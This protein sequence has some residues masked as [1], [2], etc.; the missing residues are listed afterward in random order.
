[1]GAGPEPAWAVAVPILLEAAHA[2]LPASVSEH[3]V[4]P[5]SAR[6]PISPL[7][8]L[9]VTLPIRRSRSGR[10]NLS[11]NDVLAPD[12]RFVGT[13][14]YQGLNAAAHAAPLPSN[15]VVKDALG[16]AF[17]GVASVSRAYGV[18]SAV[19]V[20]TPQLCGVTRTERSPPWNVRLKS[21]N[22]SCGR[23][24]KVVVTCP[25]LA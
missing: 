8:S 11:V 18:R 13:V 9:N 2:A 5:L 7:G 6:L 25:L 23:S 15:E 4:S 10:P 24:R 16:V 3:C 21:V 14:V 12:L 22:G 20:C 17:G 1:T 19:V